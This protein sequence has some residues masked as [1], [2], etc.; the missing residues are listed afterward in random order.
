MLAKIGRRTTLRAAAAA[1]I[2]EVLMARPRIF[3]LR[4]ENFVTMVN[5]AKAAIGDSMPTASTQN[6]RSEANLTVGAR[7][8]PATDVGVA[9]DAV[10]TAAWP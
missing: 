9:I 2:F 3:R 6:H 10:S 7:R 5:S 4:T 8:F 1:E